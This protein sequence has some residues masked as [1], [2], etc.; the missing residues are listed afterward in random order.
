MNEPEKPKTRRKMGRPSAAESQL[1]D[2]KIKAKALALFLESGYDS[3]SMEAVAKA[4]D[5]TKRS[6]YAR[7]SDKSQLFVEALKFSKNA[8][9]YFDEGGLEWQAEG[10][11]QD[12]LY[13]LAK[14]LIAQVIDPTYIKLA[15]MA[16][17]V[18]NQFPEAVQQSYDIALSPRLKSIK[19][20]LQKF[21]DEIEPDFVENLD[22]TAELFL[23][24]ITGLP[25]RLAGFGMI[26][27]KDYEDQRIRLAIKMFVAGL[28]RKPAK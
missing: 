12:A 28:S 8:W 27:E 26:R 1:L 2:E 22:V 23:G 9:F 7:Y 14:A 24:L 6:L 15:R 21:S 3:V 11:L 4:A 19:Q 20:V 25:A 5:I 18:A 10:S 16:A 13:P 17:A